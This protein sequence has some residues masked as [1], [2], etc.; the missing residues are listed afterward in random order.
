MRKLLSGGMVVFAGMVTVPWTLS[1][2]QAA[3]AA[4][5]DYRNDPR[6]QRLHRFFAGEGC[7]AHQFSD[8]FL[9][10]ADRYSLDWRLLPSISF[11][12]SSGGKALRNNNLFGWA[13]GRAVFP[14]VVAGIHT[15]GYLLA[16]SALYKDK[17]L[18]AVLA[19]YNPDPAYA[20]RV[21]SVMRRICPTR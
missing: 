1:P 9:E 5:P 18:D 16:N 7:P 19:T 13:S 6:L 10:A 2:Q 3:K 15:V 8:A 14:S 11:V 17:N 21:K 20:L 4:A 12:E